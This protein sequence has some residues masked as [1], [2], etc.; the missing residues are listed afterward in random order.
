MYAVYS[1][2]RQIFVFKNEIVRE[3]KQSRDIQIYFPLHIFRS[4][5]IVHEIFT[6]FCR[7]VKVTVDALN[8]FQKNHEN[9]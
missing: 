2:V 3:G 1:A 4:V 6:N 8:T 5:E 7:I 9:F